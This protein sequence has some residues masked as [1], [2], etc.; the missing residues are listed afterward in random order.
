MESNEILRKQF[1]EIVNN[2]IKSNDPPEAN[3]T[4]KRLKEMGYS[5]KDAKTLIGQCVI[6]EIFD[7]G[8]HGKPFDEKRY[9]KNLKNLPKEPFDD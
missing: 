9:I 1:L 8:K 3:Q 7:M 6:V 5:V 2:Q 4:F